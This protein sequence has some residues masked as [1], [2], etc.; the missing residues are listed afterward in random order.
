[1]T[2]ASA[3]YRCPIYSKRARRHKEIERAVANILLTGFEPFAKHACNPT[4]LIVERLDGERIGSYQ[5]T[6]H[7]LPVVFEWLSERIEQLLEDT[8]P[9]LVVNLGLAAGTPAIRLE[10]VALN[11][12]DFDVPD[13]AGLSC[14]DRCLVQDGPDGVF[15]TL[16]LRAIQT[17]LLAAGIPAM[18]SNSAGT[19]LCNAA[20]Y[21]FLQT[22]R[23]RPVSV[24]CGFIHVPNLPGQVAATLAESGLLAESGVRVE[25]NSMSLDLQLRAIQIALEQCITPVKE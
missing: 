20:M 3:I 7:V 19:Y 17:A 9:A 16:P 10:R 18:I 15:S 21:Y 25:L 5:I 14:Q 12:A 13:N 23:Q 24:P 1:M 4:A 2:P 6:G 8:R 22:L 11:L